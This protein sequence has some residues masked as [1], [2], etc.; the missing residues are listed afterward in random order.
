MWVMVGVWSEDEGC[1]CGQ[2]V[3]RVRQGGRNQMYEEDHMRRVTPE[4][5]HMRRVTPE[6]DHM[7]RVTPEILKHLKGR[8][9]RKK[10]KKKTSAGGTR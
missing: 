2:R 7:R 6:E 5:D 4:E 9:E 8:K 1:G 10:K 3:M